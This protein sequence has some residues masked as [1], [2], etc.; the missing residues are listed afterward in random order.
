MDKLFLGNFLSPG[1]VN[2]LPG[3]LEIMSRDLELVAVGVGKINGM[4][5]LV[6][7]K[8]EFDATLF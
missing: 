5:N 8:F 4:R 2:A 7:L 6:V 1:Q 3:S